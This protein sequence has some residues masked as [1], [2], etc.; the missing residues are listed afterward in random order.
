MFIISHVARFPSPYP[1]FRSA[2][3][4]GVYDR[5]SQTGAA[6]KLRTGGSD[7]HGPSGDEH[8][9]IEGLHP[10]AIQHAACV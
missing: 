10:E 6:H 4:R 3:D 8:G 2:V 7:D 9:A 1:A 5:R